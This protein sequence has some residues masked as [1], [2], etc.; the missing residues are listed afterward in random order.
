MQEIQKN[1]KNPKEYG[2]GS[3]EGVVACESAN[4]ATVGGALV[5]L[6]T[7][8]VPGSGTTAV[9]FVANI[10]MLAVGLMG[11]KFWLRVVQIPPQI[12]AP[13]IF[14]VSF[15]GA[16]SING[17]VGDVVVMLIVGFFG[18][19]LRKFKFPL[20]P[21]VIALVLGYMVETSLRRALILSEGSFWIFIESPLSAAFLLITVVSLGWAIY[22][23]IQPSKP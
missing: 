21:M 4:N 18:Y 7:L 8:G 9:L 13:L 12:L 2:H 23:E 19:I 14:G 6:L 20:L 3:I 22:R 16:Y 17:S 15:V 10:V 11:I 5:P 1:L